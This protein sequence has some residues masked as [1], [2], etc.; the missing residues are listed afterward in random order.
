MEYH[1]PAITLLSL[2]AAT[3]RA[4]AAY[5]GAPIFLCGASFGNRVLAEA[6]RTERES[7]PSSRAKG[8]AHLHRLP[9]H[10]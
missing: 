7:L 1:E 2:I 9:S 4:A 3:T 5:P 10:K 8:H 6:L